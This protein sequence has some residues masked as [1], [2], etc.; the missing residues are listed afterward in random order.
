MTEAWET[1]RI[2]I[3][4]YF[5]IEDQWNSFWEIRPSNCEVIPEVVGLTSQVTSHTAVRLINGHPHRG[6]AQLKSWRRDD[7]SIATT[8]QARAGSV[9]KHHPACMWHHTGG[10]QSIPTVHPCPYEVRPWVA[11][12]LTTPHNPQSYVEADRAGKTNLL[13][14]LGSLQGQRGVDLQRPE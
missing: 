13:T 7:T 1:S 10:S 14:W 11:H 8:T 5:W 3:F 6:N 4:T 12:S 9:V 2:P